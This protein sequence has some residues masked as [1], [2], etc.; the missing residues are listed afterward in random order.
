MADISDYLC[1][2]GDITFEQDP[3]NDVD[4]LILAQ[5]A[6]VDFSDIIPAPEYAHN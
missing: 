3:F 6:Y 4:N 1:W 5:I 2:R